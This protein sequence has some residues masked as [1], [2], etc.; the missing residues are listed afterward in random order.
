VSGICLIV[1]GVVSATLPT[2]QFTLGWTHSV[3]KTRW[4]ET[5]RVD[6]DR[7]ALIEARIQGMGAGMEP[8]PGARLANGWWTWRPAVPPLPALELSRSPYTGDY[9]VCFGS[10]CA[11]LGTLIGAAHADVEV[12]TVKPCRGAG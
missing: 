6:G 10:R 8:P 9:D 3:A 11:D 7:L 5:Y 2:E 1:A 4:E 12:V